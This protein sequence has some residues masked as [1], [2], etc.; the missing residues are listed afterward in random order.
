[1][2]AIQGVFVGFAI[3]LT[4][5]LI[6]HLLD[7]DRDKRKEFNE[8]AF[9]VQ[10]SLQMQFDNLK[11]GRFAAADISNA[12][13]IAIELYI[14]KFNIK[15]FR[16]AVSEYKEAQQKCGHLDHGSFVVD[17]LSE[18]IKATCRLLHYTKPR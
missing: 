18:Y 17:D 5:Y 12:D 10:T 3:C 13:F 16:K 11:S 6:K 9:P 1:V 14:S 4:G 7:I 8:I 2:N 15:R